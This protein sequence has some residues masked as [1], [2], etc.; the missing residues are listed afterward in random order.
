MAVG[1]DYDVACAFSG[2]PNAK[3]GETIRRGHLTAAFSGAEKRA[4]VL[5]NPCILAGSP[6]PSA[7][8][9]LEVAASPLSSQ[10]PKKTAEIVP[11][12]CILQ[13]AQR[14]PQGRNQKWPT[15]P[16]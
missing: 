14:Q 13:T 6:T 12:P 9:K 2:V 8:S 11:N 1:G 4:D 10:G 16:F 5:C 7:R 3:R 15:P